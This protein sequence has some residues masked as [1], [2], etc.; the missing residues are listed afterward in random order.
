V[1]LHDE[2]LRARR[3]IGVSE[4]GLRLVF[5]GNAARLLEIS[6]SEA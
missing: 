2:Q 1:N 5:A 4:Q 6:L 3:E